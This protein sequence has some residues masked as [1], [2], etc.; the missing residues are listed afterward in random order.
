MKYVDYMDVP[1]EVIN[2]AKACCA[3]NDAKL[4]F[5]SRSTDS[6]WD[7]YYLVL[8]SRPILNKIYG[9]GNTYVT[10]IYNE[11]GLN[12]GSYGMSFQNAIRDFS[13]RLS[14]FSELEKEK[15]DVVDDTE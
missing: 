1:E 2:G 3:E 12:A 7:S 10:W 5:I 9:N 11:R 4:I 14:D 8:A 15:Q 13:E 6:P